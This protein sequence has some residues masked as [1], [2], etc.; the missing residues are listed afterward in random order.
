MG[1]ER[2]GVDILPNVADQGALGAAD[3]RWEAVYANKLYTLNDAGELID[4]ANTFALRNAVGVDRTA[5]GTGYTLQ[6]PEAMR[7]RYEK[8]EDCPDNLKL[9][10]HRLRYDYAMADGRTLIQSIYDDHFEGCAA[11]EA[12]GE[13]L[14]A[15]ELPEPDNAE[16][17]WRME[18]QIKNAREWRDVINSFFHRLSGVDDAKGRKIYD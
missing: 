14:N 2:P 13:T 5:A 7:A 8:A 1:N 17:T 10:F 12:M 16:A 18:G 4:V 6:Y 3:E 11:A 9:F 15:L